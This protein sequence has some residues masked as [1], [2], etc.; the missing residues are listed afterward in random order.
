MASPLSHRIAAAVLGLGLGLGVAL[1]CASF[2]PTTA[3]AASYGELPSPVAIE[4]ADEGG[5]IGWWCPSDEAGS[6]IAVG[7]RAYQL[8]IVGQTQGYV[9]L[10]IM[11]TASGSQLGS[12]NAMGTLVAPVVDG[13]AAFSFC[14]GQ[15]RIYDAA[16]GLLGG[17]VHLTVEEK[18]SYQSVMPYE[19]LSLAIDADFS[20]DPHHSGKTDSIGWA[21][22]QL[23]PSSATEVLDEPMLTYLSPLM[24]ELSREEIFARHGY[25]FDKGY[26]ADYFSTKSWYIPTYSPE[27]FDSGLLSEAEAANVELLDRRMQLWE[28][29]SNGT[30]FVGTSGSYELVQYGE[31]TEDMPMPA[32]A[33]LSFDA[34]GEVALTLGEASGDDGRTFIGRITDDAE[35]VFDTDGGQVVASW[36]GPD[37]FFLNWRGT[38]EV[39]E[40][41][42]G[43][44]YQSFR[45]I[46]YLGVG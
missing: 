27:N 9:V 42:A 20:R 30:T 45:N 15:G 46:A 23:Q 18:G 21:D 2:S 43:L 29:L 34:P 14:D 12:A 31:P 13:T 4:A 41:W 40:Q 38:G 3:L 37:Y 7:G 1:T 5:Y 26:L 24:L 8:Q 28:S 16:L 6:V 19:A 25:I 39:P 17:Q 33:V 22:G 35:A 11:C 32:K 44:V 10:N 36:S